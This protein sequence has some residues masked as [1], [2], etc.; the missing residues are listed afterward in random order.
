MHRRHFLAQATA[1]TVAAVT[2][3]TAASE[4]ATPWPLPTPPLDRLARAGIWDSF[5]WGSWQ[6]RG[7][8][9]L[10]D[11]LAADRATFARA[12][13]ARQCVYLH[14]GAGTARGEA[15][16]RIRRNPAEIHGALARHAPHLLGVARLNADDPSR[17]L[18]AIDTWIARGPMIGLCL[19]DGTVDATHAN[20]DPILRR[21]AELGALIVVLNWF[22]ALVPPSPA[23]STPATVAALAT[24]HPDVTI[25][26]GHAGGEWEKGLRAIRAHRNVLIETSGFDPTA[27]FVEMAVRELGAERI[28]FGSHF[29]GRSL[30]TEFGKILSAGLSDREQELIFGGN[31]RRLLAPILRRKGLATSSE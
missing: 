5:Y 27:G 8:A 2:A 16:D 11:A 7:G 9:P 4:P 31:L 30:G 20:F 23:V 6:E 25:V 15:E 19:Q 17:A 14:V 22:N 28:L 3:R 10:A 13:L 29:S 24:R 12:R 21:A 1:A 26:C 18:A